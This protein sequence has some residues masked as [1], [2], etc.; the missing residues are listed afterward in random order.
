MLGSGI[1]P[2]LG[3]RIVLATYLSFILY[4][5]TAERI[6]TVGPGSMS[7]VPPPH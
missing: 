1:D 3:S 2:F 4:Q 7:G 6:L 5:T